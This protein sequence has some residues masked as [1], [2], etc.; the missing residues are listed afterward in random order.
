MAALQ[1]LHGLKT[2]PDVRAALRSAGAGEP[3]FR[4]AAVYSGLFVDDLEEG[5]RIVK[6]AA[7]DKFP[8]VR[9]GAAKLAAEK[10]ISE[11][12]LTLALRN[13]D[14][15]Q[16]YVALA[17]AQAAAQCIWQLAGKKKGQQTLPWLTS[18]KAAMDHCVE[19]FIKVGGE[20]VATRA[21]GTFSL[22]GRSVR[23]GYALIL[24]DLV[25]LDTERSLEELG[26]I[27]K[28]ILRMVDIPD[29]SKQ[30]LWSSYD[31]GLVRL[32]CGRILR[33]GFAEHATESEQVALMQELFLLLQTDTT[34]AQQKQVILT[35]LSHLVVTLGEGIYAIVKEN[36]STLNKSLVDSSR[37]VRFDAAMLLSSIGTTFPEIGRALVQSSLREIKEQFDRLLNTALIEA[38]TSDQKEGRGLFRRVPKKG[39]AI[40]TVLRLHQAAIHGHALTISLLLHDLPRSDGGVP[41]ILLDDTLD[42]ATALVNSHFDERLGLC[43][44]EATFTCVRAGYT[45]IC[46]LMSIGPHGAEPYVEPTMEM[47]QKTVK[48]TTDGLGH[49]KPAD[50]LI[51]LD[52]TLTSIV[53]FL[54]HCSE[55]IL[56]IPQALNQVTVLLETVFP[57]LHGPGR[58]AK[59]ESSPRL[60]SAVASLL[61]AFA[62]LPSGSFPLAA[63][64]VFSMAASRIEMAVEE[65]IPCSILYSLI[66]REDSILDAKTLPRASREGQTGGAR[67]IED[68]IVSI[69][70]DII[71]QSDQESVMHLRS[72]PT[73]R[74]LGEDDACFRKSR[75][76]G[77]FSSDTILT[78]P[79]TPLHEVGTWRKPIDPSASAKVRTLDAAIQAFS[80]TFGLKDGKQQQGAMDM[81][82]RLVPPFFTQLAR[83]IGIN[84]A[85]MEVD[86]RTKVSACRWIFQILFSLASLVTTTAP[87]LLLP[88]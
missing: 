79:P 69:T 73:M 85:T 43:S 3:T 54:K 59:V 34:T 5:F 49:M 58:L 12:A 27:L 52:A 15:E 22:G 21:G 78:K 26:D 81:L 72:P 71:P 40:V 53:V 48:A 63:D 84:S 61:E 88:T 70:A 7:G 76:L 82:E 86:R 6:L 20:L 47:W 33:E 32:F 29:D 30:R 41:R 11:D 19:Q 67:R 23:L 51:C 66:S 36:L 83:T 1:V 17:W 14:D 65:N 44:T 46:G 16:P 2:A 74:V 37:G 75:L 56:V 25:R 80:A 62:W 13:I 50:D 77:M 68:S 39:P 38:K 31:T 18:H 4:I 28:R 55:L 8:E 35:E 57:V 60:D 24:V 87:V 64:K 10:V 45:L 9:Y 42:K